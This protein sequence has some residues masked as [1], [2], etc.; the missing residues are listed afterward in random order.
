EGGR[1]AGK[2][3]AGGAVPGNQGRW[4][5]VAQLCG[6]G[7]GAGLLPATALRVCAQGVPSLWHGDPA[8]DAT[9]KVQ[10]L[11]SQLPELRLP[12]LYFTFRCFFSSASTMGCTNSW[13]SPPS[14][15]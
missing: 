6:R 3:S 7:W 8:A 11:L 12:R 5:H 4:D 2:G 15:A 1:Q 9:G 14:T 13:T 10:L